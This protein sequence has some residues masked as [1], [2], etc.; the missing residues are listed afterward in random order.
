MDIHT[1]TEQAYKNGYAKGYADGRA[2]AVIHCEDCDYSC[3]LQSGPFSSAVRFCR[4]FGGYLKPVSNTDFCSYAKRKDEKDK[5][6][7][8]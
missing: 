7:N 3:T 4:F 8:N 5:H 1:A 2:S 6:E